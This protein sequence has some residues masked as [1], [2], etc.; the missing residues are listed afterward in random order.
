MSPSAN[1]EETTIELKISLINKEKLEK[2]AAITGLNLS[3]YVIHQALVAAIEHIDTYGKM[4]L[5]TRDSEIFLAALEN[6]PEPPEALRAAVKEHLEE[7][8]KL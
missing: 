5:S 3:D 1:S 2:A 4:V 6:P 7:Y 8:G